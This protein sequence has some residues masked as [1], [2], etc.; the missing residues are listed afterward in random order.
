MLLAHNQ[1]FVLS[2][3]YKRDTTRMVWA[4]TLK[5][6]HPLTTS[7]GIFSKKLQLAIALT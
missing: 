7:F 6:T 3:L 1:A 5:V 2:R 4:G